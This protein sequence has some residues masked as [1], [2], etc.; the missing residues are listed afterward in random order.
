MAAEPTPAAERWSLS[1]R[2]RGWTTRLL[3][4]VDFSRQG[5]IIN[6]PFLQTV[7]RQWDIEEW[8]KFFGAFMSAKTTSDIALP[9][10]VQ[11][12]LAARTKKIFEKLAPSHQREYLKWI[13]SAKKPE[14]R[15]RRIGR[16]LTM[17]TTGAKEE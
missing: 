7:H 4:D 14:T 5:P 9:T 15:Q 16:M 11:Q 2:P 8:K 12:A 13:E 3:Y 1:A 6:N 10:D 17:L